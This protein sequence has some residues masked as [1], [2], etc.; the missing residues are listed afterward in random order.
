VPTHGATTRTAAPATRGPGAVGGHEPGGETPPGQQQLGIEVDTAAAHPEVQRG[1]AGADFGALGNGL[2]GGDDDRGEVGVGGAQPVGVED[3]HEALIADGTGER[4]RPGGA[5][6]DRGA[7]RDGVV[8]AAVARAPPARR[9]A[10][11]VDDRAVD[12]WPVDDAGWPGDSGAGDAGGEQ[13]RPAHER[14]EADDGGGAAGA[15][16]GTAATAAR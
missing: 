12:G 7:R 1:A 14:G 11:V 15:A 5:G 16:G 9:Q 8:D 3:G 13:Q 6:P 2:T 4:H 10:E